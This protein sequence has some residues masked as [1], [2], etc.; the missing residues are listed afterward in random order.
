MKKKEA[1]KFSKHFEQKKEIVYSFN[2]L[3]WRFIF[4]D[5]YIPCIKLN[6]RNMKQNFYVFCKLQPKRKPNHKTFTQL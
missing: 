2:P 4:Y 6:F 1:P 3:K 5:K